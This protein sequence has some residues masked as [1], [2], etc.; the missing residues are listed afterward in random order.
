MLKLT[1]Q[2]LGDAAVLHCQGQIV[3]GDCSILCNAILSQRHIRMLVLNLAR[4][5]R[6]DAGG[7]GVLLGLREWARSD[8]IRFRLMNVTKMVEEILELTH[9]ERVFESCSIRE[10]FCLLHRA[11]SLP[12]S[13]YDEFYQGDENDSRECSVKWPEVISTGSSVLIAEP[14]RC[15]ERSK[16]K[17]AAWADV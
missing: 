11:A 14:V 10:L 2:K 16:K 6:I 15:W 1:V 5:D 9:L 13:S 4:V 8:A 17:S 3:A 12:C 7:L